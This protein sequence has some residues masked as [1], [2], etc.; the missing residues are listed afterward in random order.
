M[1]KTVMMRE[2]L[3][4]TTKFG[5]A[6]R[7]FYRLSRKIAVYLHFYVSDI[8]FLDKLCHQCIRLRTHTRIL[9]HTPVTS[10]RHQTYFCNSKKKKRIFPCLLLLLNG[11]SLLPQCSLNNLG[12]WSAI[13]VSC[14]ILILFC[15]TTAAISQHGAHVTTTVA[16]NL[17]VLPGFS[18]S[19]L[20]YNAF[21]F[22]FLKNLQFAK[23][24]MLCASLDKGHLP[25]L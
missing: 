14:T 6:R 10:C 16:G 18:V 4:V 23:L 2:K 9:V 1:R 24:A 3:S 8:Y 22:F 5:S 21:S 17:F 25:C 19:R 15:P 12:S 13:S 20:Y 11:D 7:D